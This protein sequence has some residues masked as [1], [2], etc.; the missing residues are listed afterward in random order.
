MQRCPRVR[1][2]QKSATREPI[3]KALTA[4]PMGAKEK[5]YRR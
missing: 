5:K 3:I 1:G 4:S 2:T